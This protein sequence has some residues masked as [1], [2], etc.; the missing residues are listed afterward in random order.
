MQQQ[1]PLLFSTQ[2]QGDA[3]PLYALQAE[4]P[5]EAACP[6]IHIRVCDE[7]GDPEV[8]EEEEGGDE[9]PLLLEL[10]F[11]YQTAAAPVTPLLE[12]FISALAAV[13]AH[14]QHLDAAQVLRAAT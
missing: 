3:R 9:R 2:Q 10:R 12:P 8:E 7:A 1:P 14:P 6:G 13:L 5:S 11:A 4:A